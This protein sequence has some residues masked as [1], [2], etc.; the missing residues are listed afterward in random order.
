MQTQLNMICVD[1]NKSYQTDF[2]IISTEYLAMVSSSWQ[3][4]FCFDNDL[5]EYRQ[6][7]TIWNNDTPGVQMHE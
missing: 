7:A 5:A 6:V 4:G 1:L 2:E 3:T